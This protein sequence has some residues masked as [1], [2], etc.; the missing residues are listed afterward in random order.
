MRVEIL[1]ADPNPFR[2]VGPA[3][4]SFSGGKTSGMM[5]SKVLEAHGGRLPPGVVAAFANTGREREET[6]EYV[7]ECG[8]RWQ[9][10]IVWLEWRNGPNRHRFQVVDFK[11]AS[12][13]GEPYANLI[14]KRGY[15]PNPVTRFCTQ[16]LKIR[17]MRDYMLSLGHTHWQ[18][19]I[20]LRADEMNRINKA[21]A[22]RPDKHFSKAYP[23]AVAGITKSDVER[24][25]RA[26]PFTLHLQQH[27]GNCD[28][29]FLKAERKIQR[30]LEDN[31]HLAAWWVEQE[32]RVGATFRNDRPDYSTMADVVAKQGQLFSTMDCELEDGCDNWSCTD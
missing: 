29:C 18:S 22:R 26:Q 13:N 15:L 19:I 32:K 31:P 17:V 3:L 7:Q 11:T 5:L 9:V 6:L 10:P 12:R 28:L 8:E 16:E 1:P 25:W 2:I 21:N 14:T 27:E 23:L 24:F 30:N 20:S 4:L